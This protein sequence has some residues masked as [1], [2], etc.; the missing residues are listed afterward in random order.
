MESTLPAATTEHVD[1]A[2]P[3]DQTGAE[4]KRG[5]LLNTIAM[6]TSNFRAV[7]TVLI[8]RLLGP[9]SL[10]IFSVAWATT[11]LFSKIGILGLDDAITTFVARAEAV[12]DHVRSR[13]LFRLAV[14]LAV[15][16]SAV[17]ALISIIAIRFF[18]NRLRLEPEMVSA[19]A[20]ILIAMPGVALYRISNSVSRGMK[21]MKHDIYSRGLTES[22]ATTL[23]FLI[24]LVIG[25]RTF[26]PELAAIAGTAASGLVAL[27][28][29]S[30]LFRHLPAESAG[31]SLRHEARRLLAYALP[32]GADQFLNAF[33]WRLDVIMLGCFVG[34]APG[35]T[36]TTLGIY[37]AV[38]GIA[39]GLRKV[40]QAFTPIFAPVV[41]GMTATG[42]HERAI[43]TYARL[44]QWM[45]WILLPFVAVLALAGDTILI[46]FGHAFQQ[47]SVWLGIVA[48]ACATNAFI[49]LG[50]TVIMVQRPGLNL[51]NSLITC[52]VG[53]SATL[54]LIPRFGVLGAAFGILLT[55]LVQGLIR[56]VLLR[57]VF[58]WRNPWS[59]IAPPVMAALIAVVPAL[60]LR[61]LLHG[62]IA[63][64]SAAAAFLVVFG[65]AWRQHRFRTKTQLT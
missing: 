14:V 22:V 54:W 49:N 56:N 53:G 31:V 26:A 46:I 27:A 55:Y 30:K 5:A 62:T 65:L 45:L 21:V 23:A 39:N 63:Q 35:V 9:V 32:I 58:R 64:V 29:A 44:A 43:A 11:D 19:I 15:S 33:I 25:F 3:V 41:A 50:E 51:L 42:E 7:F 10:G 1:L 2:R 36:L 38:V 60:V 4:L 40:S 52:I 48:V 28:L 37:G 24:A 20:V 47:G 34:R 18:G 6:V 61:A 57:F 8:A 16:Q 59:N 12:G 13:A 17:V